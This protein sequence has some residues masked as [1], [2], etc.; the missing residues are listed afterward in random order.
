[1]QFEEFR[2]FNCASTTYI[3][4]LND[5]LDLVNLRIDTLALAIAVQFLLVD[6]E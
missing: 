3:E 5:E 4:S 1:M 2:S 6:K